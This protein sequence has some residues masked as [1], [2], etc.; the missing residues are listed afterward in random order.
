MSNV[1]ELVIFIASQKAIPD[2][3]GFSDGIRF[4]TDNEHRKKILDAAKKEAEMYIE[5]LKTAPDNLYETDED[6]A[7]AILIQIKDRISKG[8]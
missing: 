8:K 3:G 6:I 2:G 4:W 5:L 7:E 1:D